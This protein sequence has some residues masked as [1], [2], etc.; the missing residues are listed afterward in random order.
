MADTASATRTPEA[1]RPHP[2]YPPRGGGRAREARRPASSSTRPS[3]PTSAS[4]STPGTPTRWSAAPSCSARDG[5]GRPGR[6]LR[7]G[8]EGPGGPARR[9]RRGRCRGPGQEDRGRLA[10]VRRRDRDA[11]HDGPGRSA[12]PDPRPPRPHAE[13]QG[14]D[15]HVRPRARD[16][17][18]KGGRVEFKVDKGAIVHVPV[19]KASFEPEPAGR[20]P[21]RARRRD[22]PREAG[23]RQGPVPQDADDRE[24]MGPGIRVDIPAVL[25]AA[26]AVRASSDDR[27]THDPAESPGRRIQT[28]T[29]QTACARRTPPPP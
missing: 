9:R 18:V 13:P 5:Q 20:Q 16:R 21:R 19:G 24:T 1:R 27:F 6:G 12:R 4:A 28:D 26:V 23:R 17:E 15:H 29:P 14:R 3:R 22:Q 2:V 10:R 8:R 11:R 7:P 25:A